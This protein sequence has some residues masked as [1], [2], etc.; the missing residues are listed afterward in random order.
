MQNKGSLLFIVNFKKSMN[1]HKMRIEMYD[2]IHGGLV[3]KPDITKSSKKDDWFVDYLHNMII[4][5]KPAKVMFSSS[6]EDSVILRSKLYNRTLNKD[7]LIIMNN[8]GD[9]FYR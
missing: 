4:T 2:Y 6:C 8:V 3:S 5:F 7:S 1:G 9:I